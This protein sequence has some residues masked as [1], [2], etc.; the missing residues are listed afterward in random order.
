MIYIYLAEGFEETEM[1]APL[2]L[3]RR[4]N[5]EVKTVS[6]YENKLVTGSHGITIKADMSVYDKEYEIKDVDLFM[7][8]GGMPGTLNLE[9]SDFVKDALN[10]AYSKDKY[11]A[12]ICAAPSVPGKMGLLKGKK[13]VCYPGFENQLIDAIHTDARAEK[14]GKIITG[15]GMG[16]AVEFGL[17]IVGELCGIEIAEKLKNGIL[18]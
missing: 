2:D 11:I 13:A 6:I 7:L 16:A 3:M 8:P 17:C 18:A 4:A 1:I 9:K 5:L 12:C 14:D 10:Y 15:I